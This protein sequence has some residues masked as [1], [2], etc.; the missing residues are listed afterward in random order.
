VVPVPFTVG[1]ADDAKIS[2]GIEPNDPAGDGFRT[3]KG[4]DGN[5]PVIVAFTR[6]LAPLL[7][8]TFRLANR[9]P[10]PESQ[11]GVLGLTEQIAI[12]RVRS[13]HTAANYIRQKVRNCLAV[14]TKTA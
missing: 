4:A 8:C 14:V 7:H 1:R 10:E 3:S 13:R 11:L 9:R 12:F 2:L 5:F 6:R